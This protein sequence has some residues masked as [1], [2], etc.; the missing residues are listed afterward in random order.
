MRGGL[1]RGLDTIWEFWDTIAILSAALSKPDLLRLD[2]LRSIGKDFLADLCARTILIGS[3]FMII[4]ITLLKDITFCTS[5]TYFQTTKH[6]FPCRQVCKETLH[7]SS[8][9]WRPTPTNEGTKL[10]SNLKWKTSRSRTRWSLVCGNSGRR[11]G[12]SEGG[13]WWFRRGST[14]CKT[15]TP[16]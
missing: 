13:D 2:T 6:N 7:V 15:E 10:T 12:V 3:H 11:R 8:P 4:L 14:Q 1:Y 16:H 9:I 5:N